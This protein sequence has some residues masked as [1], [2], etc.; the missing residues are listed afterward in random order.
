MTKDDFLLSMNEINEEYI[1]S[2]EHTAARK[3]KP[4]LAA[5]LAA[6][7]IVLCSVTAVAATSFFNT[8]NGGEIN[9]LEAAGG[10]SGDNYKVT[11]DI[12]TA[13]DAEYEVSEYYVPMYLEETESWTDV[14]G[15]ANQFGSV[16]VYDNYGENLFAIFHQEPALWKTGEAGF[17]YSMPAGTECSESY[18]EVDGEK[19]FCMEVQPGRDEYTADPFGVRILFW[20]DGYNFFS[21]ETRLNMDDEVRREIVRSVTRVDDISDYVVYEELWKDEE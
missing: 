3:I 17:V 1:E 11:F 13:P 5:L 15:E 10:Y 20:S 2:S 12:K 18:F 4:K 7:I 19:I 14:Q 21:L 9:F 16:L 8:V 6:A